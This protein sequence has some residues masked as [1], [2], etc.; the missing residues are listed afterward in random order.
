MVSIINCV[1]LLRAHSEFTKHLQ[2]LVRYFDAVRIYWLQETNKRSYVGAAKRSNEAPP[3]SFVEATFGGDHN[4]CVLLIIRSRMEENVA[5][6]FFYSSGKQKQ[7]LLQLKK[8]EREVSV[9]F[10]DVL[11]L[12]SCKNQSWT[13]GERTQSMHSR[14]Y[15]RRLR[16]T[17][18]DN[19]MQIRNGRGPG[20][21]LSAC[22]RRRTKSSVAAVTYR[23]CSGWVAMRHRC[24]TRPSED[25][26]TSHLLIPWS[27]VTAN[28]RHVINWS[29]AGLWR[30]RIVILKL[31]Q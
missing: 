22:P 30:P 31:G 4:K 15:F 21:F 6:A 3:L 28:T 13:W 11:M 26:E 16:M 25:Q 2:P 7:S 10:S 29:W 9:G 24:N 1:L 19:V 12:S 27:W 23:C 8:T 18:V 20:T 5:L 17:G 14:W